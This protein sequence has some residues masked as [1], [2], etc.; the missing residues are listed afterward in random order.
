[1]QTILKGYHL[2]VA[3]DN[4][5]NQIVVAKMIEQLGGTLDLASDGVEAIQLFDPEKYQLALLDIEM[6]RKSGLE[7]IQHIRERNDTPADFPIIA[8]TA[9]V[10]NEHKAKIREAGADAVMAKPIVDMRKFGEE[11]REYIQAKPQSSE[12]AKEEGSALLALEGELGAEVMPELLGS[13]KQDLQ[14]LQTELQTLA[15]EGGEAQALKSAAHSLKPLAKMLGETTLETQAQ[16]VESDALS[17]DDTTRKAQAQTLIEPLQ[18]ALETL[19][20]F[21]KRYE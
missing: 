7:V 11:I 14:K 5:T 16:T 2:L 12:A 13:L 9:F 6:P 4:P 21:R 18:S 8:L 3:E 17:L 19:E 10:L 20:N 1:M 15:N